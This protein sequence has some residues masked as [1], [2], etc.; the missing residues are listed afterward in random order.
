MKE[1]GVRSQDSLR[2]CAAELRP[3]EVTWNGKTWRDMPG[4]CEDNKKLN[5]WQF[6]RGEL[7]L[8]EEIDDLDERKAK[9]MSDSRTRAFGFKLGTRR[10]GMNLKHPDIYL[11]S[12]Q[13]GMPIEAMKIVPETADDL[14]E[15]KRAAREWATRMTG[16]DF[17]Q[18]QDVVVSLKNSK[19]SIQDSNKEGKRDRRRER[20]VCGMI[21][22]EGGRFGVMEVTTVAQRRLIK[23]A[24]VKAAE[25]LG[26]SLNDITNAAC[27]LRADF[28]CES[29]LVRSD[30]KHYPALRE[31]VER[32]EAGEVTSV[33]KGSARCVAWKKKGNDRLKAGLQ[34]EQ[35][36]AA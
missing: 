4:N 7:D 22:K 27:G 9:R 11:M 23:A 28:L 16:Y 26:C 15:V 36:V 21:R 1:S 33:P 25:K 31:F 35:E 10:G 3:F 19:L 5:F 14:A 34:Q 12:S 8:H 20:K 17:T 2:G 32:V 18:I 30:S 24:A 29:C 13:G 6:K